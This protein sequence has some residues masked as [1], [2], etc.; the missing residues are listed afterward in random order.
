MEDEDARLLYKYRSRLAE[1]ILNRANLVVLLGVVVI[2]VGGLGVNRLRSSVD[3]KEMF[4]S[5]AKIVQDFHWIETKI[6][7]LLSIEAVVKVSRQDEDDVLER[8]RMV[9]AISSAIGKTSHVKSVTSALTFL[10]PLPRRSAGLRNTSRKS[11][12]RSAVAKEESSLAENGLLFVE[13]DT[14]YWRIS[15]NVTRIEQDGLPVVNDLQ[16]ACKPVLKKLKDK[17]VTLDFTGLSPVIY[18]AKNL[19]FRDLLVSFMLAFALITPVM[20][21]ILR[22]F[23]GGLLVMIP[24]VAP[25][26]VVFGA[27]GWLQV[28]VDIAS[29]L[30]ASVAF[31][32]AVDDTLHFVTWFK[33]GQQR[34]M[35]RTDAVRFAYS[36]CSV[37]MFQTTLIFCSALSVFLWVEFLP[38]R[39]FAI[40]MASMLAGAVIA[41]LVLLPAIL[42]GRT[43]QFIQAGK[44]K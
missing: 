5:D 34:G 12:F 8:L 33:K 10:P 23:L 16:E 26:A 43:G 41:D 7:P 32:I 1:L 2:L 30:T 31:G 39:T 20:M 35:R 18:E 27:M 17:N 28:P 9:R 29:I 38:I 13:G 42:S 22:S 11:L 25:V 24:N 3:L 14:E 21:W 36:R 15:A 19:L 4:S 44:S 6:A 37:A 40:L